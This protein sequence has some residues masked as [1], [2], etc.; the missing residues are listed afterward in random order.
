[1]DKFTTQPCQVN[2]IYRREVLA[3]KLLTRPSQKI[4]SSCVFIILGDIHIETFALIS[5]ERQ[6]SCYVIN[7]SQLVANTKVFGGVA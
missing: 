7:C 2:L 4:N 5:F 3:V 1:M 6:S